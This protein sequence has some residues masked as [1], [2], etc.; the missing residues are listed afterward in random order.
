MKRRF[1]SPLPEF[2][3]ILYTS[4]NSV[5]LV[6]L[7]SDGQEIFLLCTLQGTLK[8]LYKIINSI[9]TDKNS[10]CKITAIKVVE[11]DRLVVGCFDGQIKIINIF[12]G[13]LIE[14]E[15]EVIDTSKTEFQSSQPI[16]QIATE[17]VYADSDGKLFVHG[18]VV[19]D[20]GILQPCSLFIDEKGDS[21]SRCIYFVKFRSIY[22]YRLD[23]SLHLNS[24]EKLQ[25][26]ALDPSIN[27]YFC[28]S[29]FLVKKTDSDSFKP[30]LVVIT[31]QAE[32]F[33]LIETNNTWS[34][35]R[36]SS[37][38]TQSLEQ[39]PSLVSSDGSDSEDEDENG[40]NSDYLNENDTESSEKGDHFQVF[41]LIKCPSST[42]LLILNVNNS[43]Q[44]R[45]HLKV[46][47]GESDEN[48]DSSLMNRGSI[49]FPLVSIICPLC[50]SGLPQDLLLNTKNCLQGHPLT[51]CSQSAAL[52]PSVTSF[53]C[54]SCNA[55]Y[56]PTI[57]H[58]SKC[59]FCPGLLT[60]IN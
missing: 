16:L 5:T 48:S 59:Q 49:E 8:S 17:N 23:Q 19:L 50:P 21:N 34:L 15:K 7:S 25:R 1:L 3:S 51:I 2:R 31:N 57:N 10:N 58:P 4:H 44:K 30:S 33:T 24:S 45:A 40:N 6:C 55:A 29:E 28:A 60:K 26:F 36:L 38:P 22:K 52:N 35:Q 37:T 11:G 54:R 20:D 39:S 18:R 42:D 53:R 13:E 56:S 12:T 46:I 47:K 41:G 43:I 27:G 32:L 9:K 14:D